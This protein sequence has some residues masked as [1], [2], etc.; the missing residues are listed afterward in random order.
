M[1]STIITRRAMLTTAAAAVATGAATAPLAAQAE[2]TELIALGQQ[3]REL[4]GEWLRCQVEEENTTLLKRVSAIEDR[5]T[6]I[7]ARPTAHW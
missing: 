6:E 7:P 5:M 1:K 3:W 4:Y 2:D